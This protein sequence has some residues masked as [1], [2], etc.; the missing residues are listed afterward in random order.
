[1]PPDRLDQT[2]GQLVNQLVE[3][4]RAL[5]GGPTNT[6]TVRMP[7]ARRAACRGR[8]SMNFAGG[9]NELMLA[10]AY[11]ARYRITDKPLQFVR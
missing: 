3:T 1:M 2:E 5:P 8:T 7:E 9:M 6:V 11:A 10:D 4:L